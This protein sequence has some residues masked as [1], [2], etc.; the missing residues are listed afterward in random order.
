MLS[1][2]KDALVFPLV[3]S[4]RM[5]HRSLPCAEM[6]CSYQLIVAPMHTPL[7]RLMHV[8][9]EAIFAAVKHSV[10]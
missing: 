10:Q 5:Q 7:L 3:V 6:H 9:S 2:L 1:L 8:H 4:D